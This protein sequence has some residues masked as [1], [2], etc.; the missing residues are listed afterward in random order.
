MRDCFLISC[1]CCVSMCCNNIYQLVPK[2]PT[3]ST[4]E[5]NLQCSFNVILSIPQTRRQPK[6]TLFVW[7]AWL[8]NSVLRNLE[9]A[10]V[11]SWKIVDLT[12][13]LLFRGFLIMHQ[14]KGI[15]Q[16]ANVSLPNPLEGHP[17]AFSWWHSWGWDRLCNHLITSSCFG[18]GMDKCAYTAAVATHFTEGLQNRRAQHKAATVSRSRTHV[19]FFPKLTLPPLSNGF[20]PDPHMPGRLLESKTGTVTEQHT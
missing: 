6:C 8:I 10:T 5:I 20:N 17:Q 13:N 9:E 1:T 18:V 19:C 16:G 3:F 2:T 11:Q 15:G 14:L 4:S 12:P 7:V